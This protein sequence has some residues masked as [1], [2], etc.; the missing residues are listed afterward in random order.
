MSSRARKHLE[1]LLAASLIALGGCKQGAD[2]GG[3]EVAASSTSRPAPPSP[4]SASYRLSGRSVTL[5]DGKH[6]EPAA[7]GSAARNST[8]VWG[9]PFEADLDGDG[10]LDAVVILVNDGG[11]S[12]TF[13]Y[14]AAAERG[15]DGYRGSAAVLLGDRI[16][17]QSIGFESSLVTVSFVDRRAAEPASSAP[18]VVV[19]RRFSFDDG[20]LRDVPYG[21]TAT[22]PR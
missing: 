9:A 15:T 12:G 20:E 3:P 19:S 8:T 5:R 1:P 2:S 13:Y 4:L 18:S 7:P 22:T 6:D 21:A 10:D 17:P 16:A 11:G 14:V